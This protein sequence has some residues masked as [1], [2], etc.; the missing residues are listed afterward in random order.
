[1]NEGLEEPKTEE[2]TLEIAAASPVAPTMLWRRFAYAV[3]FVVALIA[4]FDVWSQVG[5]Q[6][7]LDLLPWYAKLAC[8]LGMS[9]CVVRFTA[10]MAEQEKVW[11][12][13]TRL[14]FTGMVAVALVMAAI[15]YYVH[16]H[17][18]PDE[19]DSDDTAATSGSVARPG[20]MMLKI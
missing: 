9:W 15:T 12:R 18:V 1:V 17:E 13:S 4:V 6:G 5:G 11:N 19:T 7:H 2:P 3:E 20:R 16:L 10:G 14:W 8:V